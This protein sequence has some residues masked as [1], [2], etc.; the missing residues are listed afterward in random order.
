MRTT[1]LALIA[2]VALSV[3][4]S[5][6]SAQGLGFYNYGSWVSPSPYYTPYP[7]GYSTRYGAPG[8]NYYGRYRTYVTPAP[9]GSTVYR[10]YYNRARPL[11]SGPTHSVYFDPWTSTYQY[12]T[13]YLNSPYYNY[14][15]YYGY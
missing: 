3:A 14:R 7:Y 11:Y 15:F 4:P 1:I 9:W 12:G 5:L 13:G 10:S 6:A 2:G 8:S